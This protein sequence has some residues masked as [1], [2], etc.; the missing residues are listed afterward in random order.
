[1][2]P[3]GTKCPCSR[4]SISYGE[5]TSLE[6]TYH[7][8]CSSDFISDRWINA[9]YT[10]SNATYFNIRDFRSFSSAQFQA[11]ATY[12]HLSKS[13]VQQ[14]IDTFNQSTFISL[15]VLSE[16]NFQIEIQSIIYQTQQIVPQT[17]TNQ[18]DL[19]IRMTMG[20]KIVS[21]LLTNYIISYYYIPG[22]LKYPE[23]RSIIYHRDDGTFCDCQNDLY[24]TSSAIFDDIFQAQTRYISNHIK[25]LPGIASGCL[26]IISILDSTL[27]C[28]Y[29]QTC[30]DDMLSYFPTNEKFSALTIHIN[31]SYNQYT[32]VKKMLENLMIEQWITNI[33]YD[34]Y[35][36]Q[37][38]PISCT[39]SKEE[40]HN[41]LFVITKLISILSVLALVLRLI[42]PI[43]VRFIIKKINR[44]QSP[45][46]P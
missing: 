4:I 40:R 21:G 7:Q 14:S 17:F 33:S 43:I 37:C 12:C 24:C 45:S 23:I 19:I 41:L 10:G 5:F 3:V 27:E 39:Y 32:K 34:K 29:N 20:N 6:P 30:L 13:Y 28:F 9:I 35:Y 1:N 8:I 15:S 18:L 2:L 22:Y 46:I 38:A 16:Y 26:P 42:I 31:S 25:I 36:N 11:L 44:E